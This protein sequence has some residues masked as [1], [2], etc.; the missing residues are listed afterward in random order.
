M[1]S[2]HG[3]PLLSSSP[4]RLSPTSRAHATEL[5]GN[6]NRKSRVRRHAACAA[7]ASAALLLLLLVELEIIPLPSY[8]SRSLSSDGSRSLPRGLAEPRSLVSEFAPNANL[9]GSSFAVRSGRFQKADVESGKS[10]EPVEPVESAPGGGG[11]SA[12]EW[13]K[14]VAQLPRLRAEQRRARKAQRHGRKAPG[15]GARGGGRGGVGL[16]L[17]PMPSEIVTQGSGEVVVSPN[18]RLDISFGEVPSMG[19]SR[20][21]T[22]AGG[23]EGGGEVKEREGSM[24]KG[25]VKGEGEIEESGES[26]RVWLR[27]EGILQGAFERYLGIIFAHDYERR[28]AER[29]H[30]GMESRGEER[31]GEERRGLS[32]RISADVGWKEPAAKREKAGLEEQEARAEEKGEEEEEVVVVESVRIHVAEAATELHM[33]VDE[34]YELSIA[35]APPS[36]DTDARATWHGHAITHAIIR[37]NTTTGALRA[38]ETFSQLCAFDFVSRLV[39]AKGS[40]ILI[41]DAPR[42]EYR[43]LLI[44]TARH[45][46]PVVVMERVIDSM[47]HAKL[48]VLH[49]HMVDSQSF[50]IETPS[51]PRLWLG[52]FTPLERYTTDDMRHIVEYAE[53]RGV[54]VVPELDSPAHAASWGVGYPSLLPSADCPEPLDVSNPFTFELIKGVLQD[55]RAVFKSTHI[56]LGGDEVSFDCWES[57]PT[58]KAWLQRRNLTSE[59][60]YGYFVKRVQAL[61]VEAGWQTAVIWEEPFKVFGRDL[62]PA[63]TIVQNWFDV[64]LPPAIVKSGFRM[65]FSNLNRGWYLDFTER[66]WREVYSQEPTEAVPAP[67]RPL[68]MG[69]E[70]CMWGERVD[71]SD[72]LNTV[73]PRAAAAAERLWSPQAYVDAPFSQAHIRLHMFRC[74][75]T[76][77]GI[78]AAPVDNAHARSEAPGPGSCYRQ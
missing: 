71:P 5:A 76:S 59:G 8:H 70:T 13:W 47:A 16:R 25:E 30:D 17:W 31:R 60:A 20:F 48:N 63:A 40:P 74:L 69:G 72:I 49:W 6:F 78:E 29:M 64:S 68:V 73:W 77:R 51:F 9:Y 65:I 23:M 43:G 10:A 41:R 28:R 52:A 62:D 57:S 44:D 19:G 42:F 3:I 27:N 39:T 11:K 45:F 33:G 18:L 14:R 67:L 24:E 7:V 34:S 61:A 50:P 46:L 37:A 35:H 1:E 26:R 54:M 66:T 22:A 75:L 15:D 2:G 4:S 55:L 12:E 21:G 36:H 32:E 53:E 38:L 58:I 56:H